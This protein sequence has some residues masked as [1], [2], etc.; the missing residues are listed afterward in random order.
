MSAHYE[1]LAYAVQNRVATVRLNRPEVLNS[2]NTTLRR[3]LVEA[4]TITAQDP[5]VRVI[6]LTG[7]GRAFCTGADLSEKRGPDFLPQF[8]LEDE[9]LPALLAIARAPKPV[10]AAVNGIVAGG[11]VGY[12]LA[13]D[14]VVMAD[15]ASMLQPFVSIGMIPDAGATWHLLKQLGPKRA[16]DL[17]TNAEKLPAARCVELGIANRVVPAADL[18]QEA[19]TW[20]ESLAA[21]APL[22]LRYTKQALQDVAPL[23]LEQAIRYESALQNRL[24]RSADSK[25]GVRAFLEKRPPVFHG[26]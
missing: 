19:Q 17:M 15:T 13:C 5:E 10:I 9:M 14:L 20:A 2:L 25:E 8:E 22:A 4:I 11:G 7:T 23:D 16:F 24:V 12:M 6:V 18:M 26:H 21:K 1:C 3:E